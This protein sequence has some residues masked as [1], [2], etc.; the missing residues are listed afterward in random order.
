[1]GLLF[2]LPMYFF[3]FSLTGGFAGAI[4]DGGSEDRSLFHN[5]AIGL[6]GWLAAFGIWNA[7]AGPIE[8]PN[9][10]LIFLAVLCSI[11]VVHIS[12]RGKRRHETRA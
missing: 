3:W 12:E 4:H 10:W 5:F 6:F 9:I 2:V 11:V 7:V 8:E 1:M